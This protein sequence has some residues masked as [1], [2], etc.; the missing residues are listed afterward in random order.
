MKTSTLYR[1]S[2]IY[3]SLPLFIFFAT[4]LGFGIGLIAN[5]LLG[6]AFYKAFPKNCDIKL[7]LNS[8]HWIFIISIAF[9]WCFCAGIGYFYYQSFDYHFKNAVFRDLINYDW[10]VFYDRA[11]T[12][13]VYYMGFWLIPALVGKFLIIC[14]ASF[15]NA[16]IVANIFLFL[17]AFLG[18]ML[19]FLHLVNVVNCDNFK[20]IVVVILGFVLFS[21]LDIIG[22]KYFTVMGQPFEYHLEW[23]ATFLQFSSFTTSMFWVFN[24]FIPVG[25]LILMVYKEQN[26]KNFGL[27]IALSLFFAPYP[28]FSIGVIMIVLALNNFIKSPNKLNFVIENIMSIP[29]II[30]VFWILP[31]IVLYFISNSE[32]MYGYYYIFSYTTPFRLVLFYVIEFLLYALIVYPKYRKNL[33]FNV[34]VVLFLAIP[35]LRLDQQNNFC[36]RASIPL[37]ILFYCY[38][39]T[40][41]FDN[42]YKILKYI[43]IVLLC[44]GAMTPMTEFYRGFHFMAKEKR[45]NLV[46][47]DIYTLNNRYIRMPVFGYDVNH[48]YTAKEYKTDIFWQWFAKKTKGLND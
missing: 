33:I 28:T 35:F 15:Y 1:L 41:I 38:I 29:N 42:R 45:I 32:G 14:G 10:P 27:L 8:K 37:M 24:Q 36:M 6:F 40:F 13:M 23:W 3:L 43:L 44:I 18:T 48:Q 9:V 12:P 19:I 46:A 11:N 20:K 7:N 16:F 34:L 21:G 22:Y 26:I 4:W 39:I 5:L 25:I 17:F 47:D 2:Y 30:S 31:I